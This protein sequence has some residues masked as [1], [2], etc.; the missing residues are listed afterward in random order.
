[1]GGVCT[2]YAAML[3]ATY[4]EGT[5]HRLLPEKPFADFLLHSLRVNALCH[6]LG[7]RHVFFGEPVLDQ[8]RLR[9][10]IVST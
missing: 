9:V 3:L 2:H 7:Q 10:E 5:I 1:M 8:L 4:L 6:V